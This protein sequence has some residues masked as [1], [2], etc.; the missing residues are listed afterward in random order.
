MVGFLCDRLQNNT[1]N[2]SFLQDCLVSEGFIHIDPTKDEYTLWEAIGDSCGLKAGMTAYTRQPLSSW[3]SD[4]QGTWG[5][6]PDLV[7]RNLWLGVLNWS[8]LLVIIMDTETKCNKSVLSLTFVFLRTLGCFSS[9]T[10]PSL[11][12]PQAAVISL[13][14][15]RYKLSTWKM[16]D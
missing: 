1:Y 7:P 6:L 13:E 8:L 3:E 10:I 12:L 15:I 14:L 11:P 2:M 9:E 4:P 16:Q 5:L